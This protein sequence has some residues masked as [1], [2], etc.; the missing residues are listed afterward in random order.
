VGEQLFY[1]CI[2]T[3]IAIVALL[4]GLQGGALGVAQSY[5]AFAIVVHGSLLWGATR[6]GPVSHGNVLRACYPFVIGGGAIALALTGLNDS[7]FAVQLTRG[8]LLLAD[9]AVAYCVCGLTLLCSPE[10]LKV[11]RD[12]WNLRT[13]FG[14]VRAPS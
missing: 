4:I 1:V 11:V 14:Q 5:A 6:T 10:G 7:E 2:K 12:F 13:H 3:A 9:V 8:Q